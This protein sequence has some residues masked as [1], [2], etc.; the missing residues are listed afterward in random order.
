MV[1]INNTKA[2]IIKFE[3]GYM[4]LSLDGVPF[5][6]NG[7]SSFGVKTSTKSIE[8]ASSLHA[9]CVHCMLILISVCTCRFTVTFTTYLYISCLT[10]L[11]SK[12]KNKKRSKYLKFS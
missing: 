5:F 10:T 9:I 2:F 8:L 4:Y 6:S 11:N 7:A 12:T 1:R 3:S